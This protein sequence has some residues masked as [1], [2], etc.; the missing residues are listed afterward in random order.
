M[1]T[2]DTAVRGRPHTLHNTSANCTKKAAWVTVAVV[3]TTIFLAVVLGTH[4][5]GLGSVG[6]FLLSR[7]TMPLV[8]S[9]SVLGGVGLLGAARVVQSTCS[10]RRRTP[11]NFMLNP[12]YKPGENRT[13]VTS[14]PP[15]LTDLAPPTPQDTPVNA[16]AIT[17]SPSSPTTFDLRVTPLEPNGSSPG[18]RPDSTAMSSALTATATVMDTRPLHVQNIHARRDQLLTDTDIQ[19]MIPEHVTETNRRAMLTNLIKSWNE[20]S[21]EKPSPAWLTADELLSV[22]HTLPSTRPLTFSVSATAAQGKRETMEDTHFCYDLEDGL[23]AGVCDGHGGKDVAM[24]LQ[25]CFPRVFEQILIDNDNNAHLAFQK[26]AES[27]TE[28]LR[29]HPFAVAK[30]STAVISYIDKGT[31]IVYTATWGDS[32]ANLYRDFEGMTK[33]LPLSPMRDFAS[34][35]NWHM[36]MRIA[37]K[38]SRT[39]IDVE[40]GL[41]YDTHFDG[42]CLIHPREGELEDPKEVRIGLPSGRSGNVACAFGDFEYLGAVDIMPQITQTVLRPGDTLLLSC[43]G[44]KDFVQEEHTANHI[45]LG[46]PTD[47]IVRH[48]I[49]EARSEDNVTALKMQIGE[50]AS[51]DGTSHE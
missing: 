42:I 3:A 6:T 14:N 47:Y 39:Y 15:P 34:E 33:S 18:G 21:L 12:I 32:E 2:S 51:I 27:I 16:D 44:L 11:D 29:R 20:H 19:S 8:V 31:H 41:D 13:F 9:T 40:H 36:A 43:D 50:E 25:D 4:G 49:V 28:D 35:H 45:S 5:G 7:G 17:I 38:E 10:Q 30:G 37:R 22:L 26:T 46:C 48:A 23:L 24:Y 1:T